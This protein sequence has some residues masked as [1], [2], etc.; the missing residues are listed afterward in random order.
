MDKI[1]LRYKKDKKVFIPEKEVDLPDNFEVE[2]ES[3][4]QKEEMTEEE[5]EK[6]VKKIREEFIKE[7]K[8]KYGIDKS[9]DPFIELIG[10]DAKYSMNTSYLNDKQRIMEAIWEKYHNE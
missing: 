7:Y 8:E 5:I 2:I 4:T 6:Y 9:N 1:K 10:I 3:S